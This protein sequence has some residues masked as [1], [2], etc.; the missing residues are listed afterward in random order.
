MVN[1]ILII[2]VPLGAAFLL[3]LAARLGRAAA[4]ALFYLALFAVTGIAARWA[5]LLFV[6]GEAPRRV[7]TA[8][9]RPPLSIELWM[10]RPEAV[11]VLGIAVVTLAGALFMRRELAGAR[12]RALVLLFLL[13]S[14]GIVMTRDLFNLFV[15]LEILSISSYAL[16]AMDGRRR[17]TAAAFKYAV[18]GGIASIAFLLGTI[19]LY[20]QTGTLSIDGM[21]AGAV[22]GPAL[23][24]LFLALVVEM[25]QFPANGWAL[26]VYEAAPP[27]V[28]ALVSAAGSGAILYALWKTL[29]LGGDPWRLTVAI[30]GAATFVASGF[31]GLRQTGARRLLGYSS[32]GQMGLLLAAA[33]LAPRLGAG[34]P[35]VIGALFLNHLLAKAGLFWLAGVVGGDRLERWSALR[36]RP[37]LLAC[38]GLFALALAGMPPFAGFWGK[39]SLVTALA[40]TGPAWMWL[41]LLGSLLEAAYLLRWFG[42]AVRRE[43]DGAALDDGAARQLPVWLFALLALA[44]G[45]LFGHGIVPRAGLLLAASPGG[46]ASWCPFQRMVSPALFAAGE[47]IRRWP[48]VFHLPWLLALLV[49]ALGRLPARARG[50]LVLVSVAAAGALVVPQ[51][52]GLP[53][54]F[55]AFFAGGGLL[56]SIAL[57]SRREAGTG[58]YALA[59]LML[60]SL[61]FLPASR[62][63]L[64]FFFAWEMMT[65]SS[66][67]LVLRGRRAGRAAL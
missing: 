6:L 32:I 21:T 5:H 64:Q 39:W 57:L 47:A 15:F 62:N 26:D 44:A 34:A 43:N 65:L 67:G 12:D 14:A 48:G 42:M 30:V 56:L 33:G 29:P 20:G 25:K 31:M 1:P 23:L 55:A 8:G 3:P 22:A 60:C 28:A 7:F 4:G 61:V 46:A 58:P 10:G 51:L 38:F 24:L 16:V 35:V 63:T 45:A 27:G 50:G 17:P 2:A 54:V 37:A 49:A 11:L 9:A 59:A 18:A 41:V 40:G 52:T 36:R 53:L 13:G 66:W 19:L